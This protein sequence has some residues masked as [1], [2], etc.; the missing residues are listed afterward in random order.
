L[1]AV[2]QSR[3]LTRGI[4]QSSTSPPVSLIKED[5]QVPELMAAVWSVNTHTV[6]GSPDARMTDLIKAVETAWTMMT[7]Q[8]GGEERR[9]RPIPSTPG[10]ETSAK[11][12]FHSASSKNMRY[13]F[14]APEYLFTAKRTSSN[15][16]ENSH[17]MNEQSKEGVRAELVSLSLR[18]PDLLL[19]PGSIGWYKTS[20][21]AALTQLRKQWGGKTKPATRDMTKYTQ[22]YQAAMGVQRD[23][24]FLPRSD[25]YEDGDEAL[26]DWQAGALENVRKARSPDEIRIARNTCFVLKSAQ[27]IHRYDK[28]FEAHDGTDKDFTVKEL[29][30]PMLL[31]PGTRSPIFERDGIRYGLEMCA[32]HNSAALA[33]HTRKLGAAPVDVQV[34]MSAST[35]LENAHCVA[36][37]FVIQSDAKG[38]LARTS[39]SEKPIKPR[40]ERSNPEIAV[41]Q[42]SWT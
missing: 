6:A 38:A 16:R 23:F 20:Q 25:M 41:Y 32:D 27:I 4:L 40:I 33:L 26:K 35:G 8:S 22:R 21:R 24:S 39:D 29:G 5:V 19:I 37:R 7:E 34:V 15:Q 17:F 10:A 42:L 30:T 1:S 18:F 11:V 3:A 12:T 9:E 13:A 28:V 36:R 14:I 31:M 2:P